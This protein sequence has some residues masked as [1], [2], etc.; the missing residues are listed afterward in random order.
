MSVITYMKN[1][2]S[3]KIRRVLFLFSFT[4]LFFSYNTSNVSAANAGT[5]WLYA[6]TYSYYDC[7]HLYPNYPPTSGFSWNSTPQTP[8]S[9]YT[10]SSGITS[11]YPSYSYSVQSGSFGFNY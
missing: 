7:T 10:Y 11:Q 5:I 2:F 9:Y 6:P 1:L 4:L 8:V 3:L